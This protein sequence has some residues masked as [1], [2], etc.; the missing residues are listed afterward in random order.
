MK[1]IRRLIMVLLTLTLVL[2]VPNILASPVLNLGSSL[3]LT[4]IGTIGVCI[5]VGF[6][7]MLV[8]RQGRQRRMSGIDER[9]LDQYFLAVLIVG[10]S[11]LILLRTLRLVL[12]SGFGFSSGAVTGLS[13]AL[14]I[15]ILVV[16]ALS[17]LHLRSQR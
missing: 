11:G 7:L 12:P 10:G 4:G 3:T 14:G 8:Q 17:I 5:G 9:K 15:G 2:V 6:V 1:Q 16:L 13:V